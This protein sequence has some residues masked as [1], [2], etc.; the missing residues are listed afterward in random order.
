MSLQDLPEPIDQLFR[1]PGRASLDPGPRSGVVQSQ[2]IQRVLSSC[3]PASET[4][5]LLRALLL[6]WNDHHD[7]AHALVQA[8]ENS[9]G[10]LIHAILHRR[11]PDYSNA[12]YWFHRVGRH[13]S[14]EPLLAEV[15][16][17]LGKAGQAVELTRLVDRRRW[18]PEAFVDLCAQATSGRFTPQATE[19]LE[20]VQARETRSLAAHLLAQLPPATPRTSGG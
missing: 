2:E 5:E 17:L 14:Y 3:Y 13:A 12:K 18:D 19:V 4:R 8:R 20:E 11:E 1:R 16:V 6:L 10:N 9:D 15:K 7:E